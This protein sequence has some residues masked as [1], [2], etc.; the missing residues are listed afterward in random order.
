MADSLSE[1]GGETSVI[2]AGCMISDAGRETEEFFT[3]ED[4]ES[5]EGKPETEED[6]GFEHNSSL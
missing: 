1:C 6:A 4:T 3:T 5:T 2:G